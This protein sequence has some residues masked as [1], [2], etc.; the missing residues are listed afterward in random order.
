MKGPYQKKQREECIIFLDDGFDAEDAPKK[1]RAAGFKVERFVDNF[2][3]P[4][5]GG[6]EQDV[7]DPRI[8][9]LCNQRG[10]LLVTTDSNMRKTHVEEI[11]KCSNLAILATAHNSVANIDEWVDG[12]IKAKAKVERA[13]KKHHRPW[14]ATYNRGGQLSP[15]KTITEEHK[16]RRVR[17][18]EKE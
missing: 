11:K 10:W 15:P 12:L 7:K 1:L 2:K 9:R 6:K 8:I 4:E 16:T 3:R 13:F 5:D 14:Y 17:Q 18:K